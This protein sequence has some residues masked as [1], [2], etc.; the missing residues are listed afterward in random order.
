MYAH[1]NKGQIPLSSMAGVPMASTWSYAIRPYLEGDTI[2]SDTSLGTDISTMLRCPD[3]PVT[4]D[5]PKTYWSYGKNVWLEI[6]KKGVL[7]ASSNNVATKIGVTLGAKAFVDRIDDVPSTSSTILVG[8]IGKTSKMPD[9]AMT[10]AWY[11]SSKPE[12]EV[13]QTRHGTTANYLWVDGHVSAEVFSS[14]FD[15]QKKIDRWCPELAARP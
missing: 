2:I 14:T 1:V 12:D 5:R 15:M 3:D 8:E 13:A 6:P 9:H 7:L 10:Y 4:D 11:A